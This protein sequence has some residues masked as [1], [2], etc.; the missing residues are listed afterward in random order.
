ML[1]G[2]RLRAI[3]AMACAVSASFALTAAAGAS[4]GGGAVIE[5]RDACDPATFGPEGC[6]RSDDSGR[7]VTIDE[8]IDRII[9]T[10]SHNAWRFSPDNIKVDAGQPLVV[11]LGQGGEFHT[12]TKVDSFGPGC[13]GEIN[14]LIF[15]SE[16][17]PALC[18]DIVDPPGIPRTF[19]EDGVTPE[20]RTVPAAALTPG[21]NL[22]QC[23]IHPWMHAT[24]T[25]R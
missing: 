9:R 25:V 18:G 4:S 13:I 8:A 14:V 1:G 5:A 7:R 15:G 3:V 20:A 10:G 12:F 17:G 22:F 24:V 19:L 23:M 11:R 2:T 6:V 16:D 21:R